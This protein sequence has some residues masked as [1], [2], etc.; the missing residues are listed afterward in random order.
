MRSTAALAFAGFALVASV[1]HAEPPLRHTISFQGKVAGEQ[2]VTR[3]GDGRVV[4]DYSYRNNGRGPDLHEEMKFDAAGRMVSFRVTGKSTLGAPVDESF[5][6]AQGLARWT[7]LADKGERAGDLSAQYVPVENSIEA[8]A[9]IARMLLRQSDGK[10]AALP[11]GRLE[12]RRLRE[13][14]VQS[15][16]RDAKLA[17]YAIL[18]LDIAP[19]FIWLRSDAS[20]PFFALVYPGFTAIESGWEERAADLLKMQEDAE[21]DLLRA[22]ALKLAHRFQG[23]ILIRSVRVFDSD[24]ATMRGPFDVYVFH[25]RIASIREPGSVARD[26]AAVI[27]GE[28]RYLL[29][30]LFDMHTHEWPW[31]AL[32][33]VACGVT[34]VRDMGNDNR[35]LEALRADIEDGSAV[36]P[37]IVP[38]GLIEGESSYSLRRAFVIKS[39]D[40]GKAAV[41]WYA[42]RGRRQIKLYNSIR[43]EWVAPIAAYA[44]AQGM[45]V[46]GHIPAF[47]RA[48]DAVRAGYDEI[49]HINQ[50]MLNFLVKPGDDTRTLLRFYLIGDNAGGIDLE[51]DEA[52]AFF[53]LLV[54]RG[55]VVDTTLTVFEPM[56]TQLQGEE[57]PAF[58][59]VASHVPPAL[60]RSWLVNSMDVNAGNVAR[61]RNSHAKL[62]ELA[63]RLYEAGVPLLAGTDNI[64]GF[65]LHRELETY[66]QA[67]I[68]APRRCKSRRE[69]APGTRKCPMFSAASRSASSPT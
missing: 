53:R 9:A 27:D 47:M 6:Y 44:H 16:T 12:I 24:A 2:V 56:L 29:P 35:A 55:T 10:L 3:T 8:L 13:T 23:P 28:G 5:E 26:V 66:V 59:K 36:G 58:R 63:R 7:S 48:E 32:L 22:L 57:N 18:G 1:S 38:T 49:Q 37:R 25:G 41:D 45:R 64:A 31:N 46:G 62:L 34:T 50:V 11:A 52:K 60:Q 43:P 51:S 42:Q 61:Y 19:T 40:E 14:T 68:G 21:R 33:Q 30:G 20:K 15:G 54:G 65:T 67:G 69:T 39:V 4:V 17:L